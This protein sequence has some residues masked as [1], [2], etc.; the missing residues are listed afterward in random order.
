MDTLNLKLSDFDGP[1]DLLLTLV[2]ENKMDIENINILTIADQYLKFIY[3]QKKLEIN[4]A[5]EYLLIASTLVW[6]K[7]KTILSFTTKLSEEEQNLIDAERQKLIN[8]IILYK[9]Y[10]DLV[11]KFNSFLEK[12]NKLIS[13][14]HD[15][16][17]KTLSK[18]IDKEVFVMPKKIN[19]LALQKA[20]QKA[21][22]KW[23]VSIFNNKKILV[24]EVSAEQ[25][26]REIQEIFKKYPDVTKY[27]LSDFF[28][29]IDEK[30]YSDQYL[31]TCFVCLLD[32][33][34]NGQ[35]I[36]KQNEFDDD[37][38]FDVIRR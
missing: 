22:D 10:K 30:Y 19:F 1:M 11:P 38:Y 23:K 31:V 21:Y 7:S 29:L 34:K 5:S 2:R 36:L 17:E 12:R 32:L 20:M 13:K 24:Q 4:E 16:I 35:V 3:S 27:S 25:V 9:R 8:Q 14:Q 37:I 28:Q 33:A 6:I 18:T 26:E 15:D